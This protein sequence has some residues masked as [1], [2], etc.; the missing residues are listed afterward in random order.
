MMRMNRRMF[1]RNK[2]VAVER[3]YDIDLLLSIHHAEGID[4]PSNY[5]SVINRDYR[6]VFWVHPDDQLATQVVSGSPDPS[7]NQ[8]C[9]IELDKSWDCRFLY[10]EVL[11]YGSSSESNPGTSDGMSL[12]GRVQIP[13]PK[14]SSKTGGRY[15]L[16]RL[17]EDGYKA[18]GHII[19]SMQLVKIN[20]T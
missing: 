20:I 19:L 10:V 17:Q 8:K 13:L 7:W 3:D 4:N 6:V 11:R 16:V 15:G 1:T 2:R 14:L 9:R 12:V 18:E 5:P